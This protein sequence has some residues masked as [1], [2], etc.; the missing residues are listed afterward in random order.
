MFRFAN[1]II[2]IF[3]RNDSYLDILADPKVRETEKDNLIKV[4]NCGKPASGTFHLKCPCCGYDSTIQKTCNSRFCNSCGKKNTDQWIETQLQVLPKANWKHITFTM[5]DTLWQLFLDNRDLLN[6]LFA[7]ATKGLLRQAKKKGITP[8]I[9]A[10]M[11]TWGRDLKGNVHIH[12]SVTCGGLTERGDWKDCTYHLQ[13]LM[14]EWR[15]GVI[16]LLRKHKATL[17]VPKELAHPKA[18]KQ[19]YSIRVLGA[20]HGGAISVISRSY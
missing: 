20:I 6:F 3:K 11:H 10:A 5:P 15:N 4:L 1:P 19:R 13:T 7:L 2:R 9:F 14:R 17:T 16:T 12:I 8:G 18:L